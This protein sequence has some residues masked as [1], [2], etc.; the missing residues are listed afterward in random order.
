MLALRNKHILLTREEKDAKQ[1]ADLITAYGGTPYFL[2]LI[3]IVFRPVG[4][5]ST[6]KAARADWLV[7]TSVN[8]VRSF[9][10]TYQGEPLKAKMAAVG[11]QTA[12]EI[13]RYGY[14][15]SVVPKIQ[16]GEAL[17][18]LLQTV[19]G[20]EERVL[21]VRGQ[22]AK[23]T[24]IY[25]LKN[26]GI[27]VEAL[28]TYDTIMP[29]EAI[30]E[31]KALPNLVFDY[32]TLTSPSTATHLRAVMEACTISYRKVACIGPRTNER[33]IQLGLTPTVTADSYSTNGLVKAML[34]EE[35][36]KHERNI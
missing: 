15:T 20:Q 34:I 16:D 14:H 18:R 3:K 26:K 2:P 9:F 5:E 36:H 4:V 35:A 1:F 19:V 28:N 32:V 24:I 25:G 13:E 10:S 6:K 7:F 11:V 30:R 22:L 31:A 17:A 33:A 21:V 12:H 29:K 23:P 27:N 8:G